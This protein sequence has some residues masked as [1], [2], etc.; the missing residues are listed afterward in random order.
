[1]DEKD[2]KMDLKNYGRIKWPF[3]RFIAFIAKIFMPSLYGF[4]KL[5][6]IKY[7]KLILKT[8][9]KFH[10]FIVHPKNYSDGEKSCYFYLHGGGFCYKTNP[11]QLNNFIEILNRTDSIGV[12]VDYS[13]AKKYPTANNEAIKAFDYICNNC[14]RYHILKDKICVAG[15]SAGGFLSLDL[16]YKRCE[17]IAGLLLYFPVVDPKMD[18]ESMKKFTNARVWN[19]KLNKKMWKI[20]LGNGTLNIDKNID[21]KQFPTTYIEVCEFDCLRDEGIALKDELI[22]KNCDVEYHFIKGAYHGFDSVSSS[23]IVEEAIENRVNFLNKI[24]RE[25]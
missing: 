3:N 16:A 5:K 22:K 6:R 1:M 9:H 19:S 10:T 24:L 21:Y 18:T 7:K 25:N 15:D 12:I 23:P 14:E 17:K 13:V 11:G 2:L 20:Y 8:D 4:L